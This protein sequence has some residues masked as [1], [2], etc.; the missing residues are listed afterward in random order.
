MVKKYK[1]M[2]V[3]PVTIEEVVIEEIKEI[4]QPRADV[5]KSAG[6]S[7]YAIKEGLCK[8]CRN[9]LNLR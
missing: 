6:C 4:V 3:E 1:K 2:K 9:C 7:N 8:I 5:C